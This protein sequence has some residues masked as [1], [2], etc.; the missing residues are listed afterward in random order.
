MRERRA[1]LAERG[2]TGVDE[3][4]AKAARELEAKLAQMA[5]RTASVRKQGK[6]EALYFTNKNFEYPESETFS[7][8]CFVSFARRIRKGAPTGIINSFAA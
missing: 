3:R 6:K 1:A 5:L 8:D 2:G 7:R 4:V